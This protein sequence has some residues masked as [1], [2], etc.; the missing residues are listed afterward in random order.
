MVLNFGLSIRWVQDLAPRRRVARATLSVDPAYAFEQSSGVY[1]K[2]L[3]ATVSGESLAE[4]YENHGEQLFDRNVRLFLGVR[5]GS[6]NAGIFETLSDLSERE[7]FW[8]YNNGITLVCDRFEFDKDTS[9]LELENFS[10]VNG[11]QTTVALARNS[12]N[13]TDEVQVLMKVLRPPET[14]IDPIIRYTNSQN[15]MKVWDILSQ[16][17][18]QR[19][20]Q[21]E[22]SKLTKPYYYVLRKGELPVLSKEEK[23][24]YRDDGKMRTI[25]HDI[26]AQYLAA[27][28]GNPWAAYREKSLLFTKY[29]DQVFPP[30]LRVEEALFVWLAGELITG[31][32]HKAMREAADEKREDRVKTLKRGGRLFALGCFGLIADLRN[33]PDF[34]RSITE[35]RIVSKRAQQRLSKYARIATLWYADAARDLIQLT[36]KELGLLI[37]SK[38]YFANIGDRIRSQYAIVSVNVD[39]LEG[40]LPKLF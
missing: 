23:K 26:L 32:V 34:R 24:K 10:I 33:S 35:E 11:C 17:R 14:L 39:W 8:A 6:V 3:V 29:Y 37:R 31:E 27:F 5:K 16:D 2:A 4:L 21:N 9:I 36:D 25:K 20:L 40:A 19:R 15:Q 18:V 1:G 38:D 30:E 7:R 22:F 13:L 12:E 28:S